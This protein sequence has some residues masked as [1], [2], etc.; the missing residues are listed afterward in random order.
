MDHN[1]VEYSRD[2]KKCLIL[3]FDFVCVILALTLA[4]SLRKRP[5]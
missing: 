5:R 3:V 2:L 1:P 4:I